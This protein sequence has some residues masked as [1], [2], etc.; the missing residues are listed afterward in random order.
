VVAA[1]TGRVAGAGVAVPAVLPQDRLWDDFFAE[2]YAGSELARRVWTN[3]GVATRNGV[4]DPRVE[5]VSGWST[6]ARMRR[7]VE[8][9]MPLG[10]EALALC[11]DDAGIDPRDV[12]QLTVVSCTGYATPG[13]DILLARDLGMRSDVQRLHVGHM[14]CYAALPGLA[15]VADAAAARGKVGLL[16]C[17]ELTSLHIQP[18]S[19]DREQMVAHSLFSDAAAAVAVLPSPAPGLEVVDLVARTDVTGSALMTWD[20]TD[21]GFR[22]GLSSKVPRVLREHVAEVVAELLDAH[23]LR[24]PDVAGWVVHPGGPRIIDVVADRLGLDSSRV[25][26]SRAVLREHG[27]CSSAT[28]LVIL[29]RLLAAGTLEAGDPVV[30]LAFGPGLTLYATLLRAAPG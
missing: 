26:D 27:N 29:S 22:M 17:L 19:A 3:S 21:L 28:V 2:H 1:W 14:G 11:L 23:G 20:V 18:P 8:E 5:D 9:A 6:G 7:F 16:L 15:T 10:K 24:V 12:D 25:A 4:V 30:C 13:L